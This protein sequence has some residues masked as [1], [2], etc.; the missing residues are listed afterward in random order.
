MRRWQKWLL[1]AVLGLG[2]GLAGLV[3]FAVT[4]QNQKSAAEG[5]LYLLNNDVYA[6]GAARQRLQTYIDQ[7]PQALTEAQ[8]NATLQR[9]LDLLGDKHGEISNASNDVSSSESDYTAGIYVS[10]DGYVLSQ[11]VGA[12][13]EAQQMR[14]VD[15]IIKIDGLPFAQALP[16]SNQKARTFVVQRGQGQYTI[17]VP[18]RTYQRRLEAPSWMVTPTVG[19]YL[20]PGTAIP[21]LPDAQVETQ[22]RA[23][24]QQQADALARL[25]QP[26]CGLIVDLRLNWGG[27]AY[28]MAKGGSLWLGPG[29][30]MTWKGLDPRHQRWIGVAENGIAYDGENPDQPQKNE[31]VLRM[32]VSEGANVARQHPYLAIL[33]NQMTASSAEM[34]TLA[35]RHLPRTRVFGEPTYGDTTVRMTHNLPNGTDLTW[36][37][38]FMQDASGKTY[39]GPIKPDVQVKTDNAT[40]GTPADP[41]IQAAQGW[42][43]EKG[44]R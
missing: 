17:T 19:Y 8:V 33:T 22:N 16:D 5:L 35:A 23:Y 30:Y 44:C 37:Y 43:S 11:I 13:A 40:F 10:D 36:S 15:R 18:Y 3:A 26:L 12:S 9:G 20:M 25:K 24:V 6:R 28:V 39:D 2:V 29:R 42:L 1:A 34:L 32:T 4:H 27:V 7:R 31:H 38:N 41:V 21:D 14:R